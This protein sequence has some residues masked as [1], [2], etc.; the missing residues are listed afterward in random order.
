MSNDV[1]VELSRRTLEATVW[2]VAPLLA[3]AVLVSF[4][5]SLAQALTSLQDSTLSTI[6]RLAA[7]GAACFLLMPWMIRRMGSFTISL[8]SNF[9]HYLQ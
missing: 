9:Q 4:L 7:V 5:I 8:F 6:P 1:V 2:I 3:I